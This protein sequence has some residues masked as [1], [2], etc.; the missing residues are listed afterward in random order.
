MQ[1]RSFHTAAQRA[2]HSVDKNGNIIIINIV[3]IIF[4]SAAYIDNIR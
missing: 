4:I 1:I 3:I 2:D